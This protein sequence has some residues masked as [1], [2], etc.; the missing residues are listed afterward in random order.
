MA[1]TTQ[2]TNNQLIKFQTNVRYDFLRS[3]RFDPF[4][5]NDATSVIVRT[6]DFTD[7]GRQVN[8]PL[9]NQ[10]S[11]R[12]VGAG[13][14]SGA[15]E[16]LDDYGFPIFTDFARNAVA[17]SKQ[18]RKDTS[19]DIPSAAKS[20]VRG[21]AKR[22]IRDD[23]VDTLLSFPT[24]AI[25][26]GRGSSTNGGNRV[27]GVKLTDSTAA[28]RNTWVTN[29]SDRVLFGA[30]GSNYSTTFATACGNVDSTND[31]L[32]AA[33]V[34]QLKRVAQATTS[35][36]SA[37]AII[38]F[39]IEGADEEWYVLFVGSRAM[40]DLRNDATM[41][42]ANRDARPRESASATESG[43]NPIFSGGSLVWDGVI[44]KEIPEITTRLTTSSVMNTIGTSSIPV[45]PVFLCGQSAMGYGIGQMPMVREKDDTDYGFVDG[46]G[47]E[48]QYGVAKI[49]RVNA[50]SSA[51]KDFGM[52]TG[53]FSGTA[54]A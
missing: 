50:G 25:Q 24:A 7:N 6:N 3:S 27:N 39:M 37:P 53:F 16:S 46:I 4:M 35:A 42:Q 47:I 10:L 45:E 1:L 13:V 36:G 51:L 49:A 43:G 21:W 31:R 5:G 29:N 41:F 8:I 2:T 17:Y 48:A 30:L 26:S 28:Q 33:A 52:V 34:S 18:Q 40:R 12:G 32:T 23:L 22:T 38:P 20:L 11:S 14:L 54:D 19:Y 44:I 15:E 9:V